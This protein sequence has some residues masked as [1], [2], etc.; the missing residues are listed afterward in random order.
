MTFWKLSSK[1]QGVDHNNMS[2]VIRGNYRSALQ[3][4]AVKTEIHYKANVYL[5]VYQITD[6][7]EKLYLYFMYF[8]LT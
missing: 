1:F 3:V 4:I 2:V 5:Y 6:K 7:N 8:V